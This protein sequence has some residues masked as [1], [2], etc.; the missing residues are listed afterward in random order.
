[1]KRLATETGAGQWGSALS[2]ACT[3]FKMKCTVYMVRCSYLQKPYRRSLMHVWGSEVIPSPSDRTQAGKKFLAADPNHPGSLGIAISEAVEDAATHEDTH[4]S[5]GSVLNHVCLH[6][7]VIGLE[8]KK[9]LEIAGEYPDVVIGC[10]GGGSN[11]AGLSF[12]FVADR[13][14]GKQ[15]RTVAVEPT[16]CPTLTKGAYRYDFGDT[17]GMAPIV[18]MYTLGHGFVPDS[19]H[20]GGLRYHGDSPL[21]SKLVKE[22]YIEAVAVGQRVVF[23][24]AVQ[25]ARTE[26]IIAAPES[27]HAIRVAVD[28]AEQAKREGKPRVILFGLSGHGHFDLSSYDDYF[29]GKL[30][31]LDLPQSRIDAALADLPDIK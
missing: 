18:R 27:A 22:G 26:G 12:P 30:V 7:T 28:E 5:L 25:F 10:C 8:C 3:L 1:V 6:Q 19:I 9:Q 4:Y 29:S 13:L 16:A 15:V 31:D 17:A 20:A 24:A 11:L 14:A 23:D 2:L 21:I